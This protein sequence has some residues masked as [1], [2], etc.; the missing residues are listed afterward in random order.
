MVKQKGQGSK[1]RKKD[2]LK[3]LKQV[4]VHNF[5]SNLVATLS[6]VI[7]SCQPI[8]QDLKS[9]EQDKPKIVATHSVLCEFITIITQNT[10]D[11]TCLVKPGQ[12]PH[13]YKPTPF[14]RKAMEQA[15]IIFYGGYELE[16]K[17][18]QLIKATETSGRK[19]PV[20][21]AAVTQPIVAEHNHHQEKHDHDH[22]EHPEAELAADPHVWHDPQ[23]AIA[24]IKYLQSAIIQLNPAQASLY[25]QNTLEFTEQLQLLDLWIAEQIATIPEE[26]RLLITT[27]DSFNYYVRAYELQDYKSLQG[28]STEDSP[29]AADVKD[30]VTE[31][32]Q[33]RVPTIFAEARGNNRVINNVAREAGVTISDRQLRTDGIGKPGTDTDSYLKMMIHNTCAI[34]E[35]LEGECQPF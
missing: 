5:F 4:L 34:V 26:K 6:L 29:T 21:E 28:L 20:Y 2:W 3:M 17:I 27:H 19:I 31:I 35:G 32:R 11:L 22:E 16:P 18:I 7:S 1:M 23:N 13:T 33:T 9:L 10:V 25:A 24:I 14:Q 30:L 12:D 15:Q 8:N